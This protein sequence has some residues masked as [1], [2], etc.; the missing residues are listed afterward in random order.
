MKQKLEIAPTLNIHHL[1]YQK[2]LYRNSRERRFRNTVGLQIPTTVPVHNRLHRE[3]FDGPPKPTKNEM[4]D[5][6]DYM[7][8]A[9][10][11][12]K[13]DRFWG[14]EAAMKFFIIREFD[15]EAEAERYQDT[16]YHLARQIGIL[17]SKSCGISFPTPE[18]L[19]QYG[20]A[21]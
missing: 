4:G 10:E 15:N 13:V 12:V 18:E 1:F 17:S 2:A 16:R 21:A 3:L 20:R 5:C 6:I 8:G 11:S 14:A 7:D 19:W 9:H